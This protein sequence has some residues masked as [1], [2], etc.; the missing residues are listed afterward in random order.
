MEAPVDS[1]FTSFV[2]SLPLSATAQTAQS[3][4]SEQSECQH[5]YGAQV[6]GH[7]RISNTLPDSI[8]RGWEI[9]RLTN[10]QEVRGDQI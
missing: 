5:P 7:N 2:P 6:Q 3:E 1:S 9:T 10:V 8:A 4:Q